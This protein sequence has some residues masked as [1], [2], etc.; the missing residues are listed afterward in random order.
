M[1]LADTVLPNPNGNKNQQIR[2]VIAA[3]V[4]WLQGGGGLGEN[5]SI[6]VAIAAEVA[7]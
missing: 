2:A 4:V 5:R 1:C 3:K 7:L 6:Q